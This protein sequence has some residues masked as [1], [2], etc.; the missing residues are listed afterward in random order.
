[1]MASTAALRLI[2]LRKSDLCNT[3][4]QAAECPAAITKPKRA[5]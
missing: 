4:L 3:V 1:M 2:Y 5:R